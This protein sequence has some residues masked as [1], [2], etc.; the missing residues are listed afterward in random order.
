MSHFDIVFLRWELVGHVVVST[1]WISLTF[2]RTSYENYSN[3]TKGKHVKTL[4]MSKRRSPHP[5]PH[6]QKIEAIIVSRI[7]GF[8]H[9]TQGLLSSIEGFSTGVGFVGVPAPLA[10][11]GEKRKKANTLIEKC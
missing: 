6:A 2:T 9:F 11:K 8:S 1:M 3:S 7:S 5:P 10:A 4:V